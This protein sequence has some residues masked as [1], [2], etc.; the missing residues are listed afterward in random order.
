MAK[1][2][3]SRWGPEDQRGALNLIG[4][5]QVLAAALLVKQ[6]K[7]IS[8]AAPI[9]A[10]M[11]VP[12]KRPRPAH[13]MDRD[14]GD[15]AGGARRPG[16]FQY[17]DDTA[18]LPLHAGTHIDCLCHVWYDDALFNGFSSNTVQSAGAAKC[19]AETLPPMVTRGV[20]L[21]FAALAGKPLDDG[22]SIGIEQVKRACLAAGVSIRDGDAVLLRTGWQEAHEGAGA[23]DY[24]A[25]PGLD[26][27]AAVYLAQA[28]AA[29]IGA[30][31]YAVEVLPFAAGT[32]FPVH[33]RLIR[34]F[35][36][37][38]LEGL[39]LKPLALAGAKQFLFMASALPIVGATG[40]PLNPI[41]VL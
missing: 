2:A 29:I 10:Q 38:L 11:A 36:I 26:L 41:A 16:G 9:S 4:P 7:A 18:L 35:G 22:T 13:F 34:D 12:P 30:D 23:P 39:V 27:E 24:N 31:N 19:G 21:D 37:P 17:A 32:V 25:E 1:E 33:Q 6:G 20:L 14:G 28:G 5:E 40:S 3:W 15:Y 8:L